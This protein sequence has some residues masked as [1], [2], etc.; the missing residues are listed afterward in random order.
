MCARFVT[1]ESE[2]GR[3]SAVADCMAAARGRRTRAPHSPAATARPSPPGRCPACRPPRPR[4]RPRRGVS[5]GPQGAAAPRSRARGRAPSPSS[6]STSSSSSPSSS[7][8]SGPYCSSSA[9]PMSWPACAAPAAR[10]RAPRQRGGR[11]GRGAHLVH[12]PEEGLA[13]RAGVPPLAALRASRARGRHL[14]VEARLPLRERGRRHRRAHV[15]QAPLLRL[16]GRLARRQRVDLD[17]AE[18]RGGGLR[19]AGPVGRPRSRSRSARAGREQGRARLFP[20]PVLRGRRHRVDHRL[21]RGR[22]SAPAAPR[23]PPRCPGARALTMPMLAS[24]CSSSAPASSS[25]SL[26]L[27]PRTLHCSAWS[28]RCQAGA[29]GLLGRG[30]PRRACGPCTA[31]A[32]PGRCAG[33][34]TAARAALR[35]AHGPEPPRS[36]PWGVAGGARRTCKVIALLRLALGCGRHDDAV[37]LAGPALWPVLVDLC[38]RPERVKDRRVGRRQALCVA[39][40]SPLKSS[41]K[42]AASASSSISCSAA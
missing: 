30:R 14:A 16:L 40:A 1:K 22:A 42:I 4:L 27:S 12:L 32:R 28:A 31:A 13:G 9:S 23:R 8:L 18:A 7:S 26:S 11:A 17:A 37:R 10:A 24:T 25:S 19:R 34:Q 6:S 39:A 3:R 29:T 21:R 35:A 36:A 33:T 41:A 38:A 5:A 20:Q 2:R 15:R